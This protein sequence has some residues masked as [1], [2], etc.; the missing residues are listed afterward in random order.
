MKKLSHIGVLGG[1]FDPIH[2]GHLR[3]AVD[4]KQHLGLDVVHLIP[5]KVPVH[6]TAAIA[7]ARARMAMLRLA[8]A[9]EPGLIADARELKRHTPSY[10][11]ETL[12]SLKQEFPTARLYLIIGADA[13]QYFHTWHHANEILGLCHLIVVS[14]GQ[15]KRDFP[16]AIKRLLKQCEVSTRAA[17]RRKTHGGLYFATITHLAISATAIRELVK[18]GLSVRYLLPDKVNR[19]IQRQGLYR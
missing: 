7:S 18:Q 17:L 10:T 8:I 15:N 2:F 5:C 14:R 19:Y 3:T 12:Q 9:D 11:L 1:T 13:L 6:K 16:Q 4:I